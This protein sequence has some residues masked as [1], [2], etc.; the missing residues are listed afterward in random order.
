MFT[1][2]VVGHVGEAGVADVRV[3]LPDDRPRARTV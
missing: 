2:A 1:I 3:V